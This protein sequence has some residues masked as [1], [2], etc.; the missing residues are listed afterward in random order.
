MLTQRLHFNSVHLSFSFSFSFS[1]FPSLFFSHSLLSF[2]SHIYI[3]IYNIYAKDPTGGGGGLK[4]SRRVE[5]QKILNSTAILTADVLFN[6]INHKLVIADT[7]FQAIINV[8]KGIWNVSQ[9]DL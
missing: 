9:P 6:T 4:P 3:Y 1:L 2:I 8:E 7:I 5:A